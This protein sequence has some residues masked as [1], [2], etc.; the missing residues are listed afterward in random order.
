MQETIGSIIDS[1]KLPISIIIIGVGNE[2]FTNMNI[3]DGDDG[4]EDDKGRKAERDL[5]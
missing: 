4:L 5:V 3:L 1:A 2:D